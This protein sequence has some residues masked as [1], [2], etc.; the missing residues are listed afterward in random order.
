MNRIQALC[1][2]VLIMLLVYSGLRLVEKGIDEITIT[3]A[4]RQALDFQLDVP[5]TL[6]VIFAGK[7]TVIN[8]IDIYHRLLKTWDRLTGIA[9]REGDAPPD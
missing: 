2:L 4:P 3:G 8:F 5:G 6:T 1:A 9:G 7:K